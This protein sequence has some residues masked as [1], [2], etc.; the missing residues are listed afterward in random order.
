MNF[1][2][3]LFAVLISCSIAFAQI[4]F[5]ESKTS[6]KVST[7]ITGLEN[8]VT[9]DPSAIDIG[10]GGSGDDDIYTV[11]TQFGT[12][13]CKGS[14]MEIK[15]SKDQ[16][17]A[18]ADSYFLLDPTCKP[19]VTEMAIEFSIGLNECGTLMQAN[20]TH[21]LVSNTVLNVDPRNPPMPGSMMFHQHQ[22]ATFR[23]A[24]PKATA[25]KPAKFVASLMYA[26]LFYIKVIT[27]IK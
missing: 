17:K 15:V 20:K 2:F 24:Y 12:V 18:P 27:L 7:R 5:I 16:L 19:K 21:W 25:T 3:N 8:S 26:F 22:T 10:V 4:A 9:H 6:P 14:R 1:L 13:D 23:C 11:P